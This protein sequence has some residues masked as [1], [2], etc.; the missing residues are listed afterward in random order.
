MAR[1]GRT[2][3]YVVETVERKAGQP[4]ETTASA[5]KGTVAQHSLRRTKKPEGKNVGGLG[6]ATDDDTP[7]NLER[8]H[9][10]RV[11]PAGVPKDLAMNNILTPDRA[12]LWT[13]IEGV[14]FGAAVG[15]KCCE[16][17]GIAH[18]CGW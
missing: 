10:V 7:L 14:R 18:Y 11:H 17:T 2:G 5:F 16:H 4:P 6:L 1:H 15:R 9:Q 8:A 13:K 3:S 12:V